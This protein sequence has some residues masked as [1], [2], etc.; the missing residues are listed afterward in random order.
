M[1]ENCIVGKTVFEKVFE[2]LDNLWTPKNEETY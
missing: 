1:M 2:C